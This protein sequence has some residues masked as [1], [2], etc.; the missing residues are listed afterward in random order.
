MIHFRIDIFGWRRVNELYEENQRLDAK[1]QEMKT[2]QHFQQ[3]QLRGYGKDFERL[4]R[5]QQELEAKI[6]ALTE[7]RDE[8][9]RKYK[10]SEDARKDLG[11]KWADTARERDRLQN[12][13]DVLRGPLQQKGIDERVAKGGGPYGVQPGVDFDIQKGRTVL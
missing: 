10:L 2:G 9:I 5:L 13:L 4:L 12:A 11:D 3:V 6:Q 1:I 7:D 8:W